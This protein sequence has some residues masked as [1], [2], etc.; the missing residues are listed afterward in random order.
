MNIINSVKD[1]KDYIMFNNDDYNNIVDRN[2]DEVLEDIDIDVLIEHKDLVV[3]VLDEIGSKAL[4]D[5]S[6]TKKVRE[7]IPSELSSMLYLI[8]NDNVRSVLIIIDVMLIIFLLVLD[9]SVNI[10]SKLAKIL[11][12]TIPLLIVVN[13]ILYNYSLQFVNEWYPVNR[14]INYY[15]YSIIS[16]EAIF[17]VIAISMYLIKIIIKKIYS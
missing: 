10:F 2:I 3:K 9:F 14:V 13:I 17:V 16:Y 1:N 7:K 12:F 11:L 4:S 5:I 15:N 8:S 6:D